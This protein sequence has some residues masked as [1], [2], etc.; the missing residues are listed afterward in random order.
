MGDY[1]ISLV[2][3]YADLLLR[4]TLDNKHAL[5]IWLTHTLDIVNAIALPDK[6]ASKVAEALFEHCFA[7]SMYR[8]G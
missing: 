5:S 7:I 2:L 4:N 3:T 8:K 1:S 6:S